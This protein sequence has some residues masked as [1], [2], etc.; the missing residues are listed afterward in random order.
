M[1]LRIKLIISG[2]EAK[3]EGWN[4]VTRTDKSIIN[5]QCEISRKEHIWSENVNISSDRYLPT[6]CIDTKELK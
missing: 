3:G 1:R 2:R 4:M 5:Y 6:K